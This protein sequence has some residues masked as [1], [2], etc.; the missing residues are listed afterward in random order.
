M[1]NRWQAIIWTNT[2]WIHWRIYA[3]HGGDEHDELN[4]VLVML[5]QVMA[6]RQTGDWQAIIQTKDGLLITEYS[7]DLPGVQLPCLANQFTMQHIT[8]TGYWLS[9]VFTLLGLYAVNPPLGLFT[10]MD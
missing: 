6:L 10:N 5:V 8:V 9:L 3:A 7:I 1:P 4:I 2:D